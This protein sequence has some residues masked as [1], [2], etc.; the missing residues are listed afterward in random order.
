[1]G[2]NQSIA[3]Y[4]QNEYAKKAYAQES[5][6]A[7][8]WPGMELIRDVLERNGYT[9]E[10]CS[11]HTVHNYRIVLASM[12]APIDWF[13]FISERV[14]WKKGDYTVIVGGAGNLNIRTVLPFADVFVFGRGEN[15]ITPLVSHILQGDRFIHSAVA[16]S[17][18]FS[19][20]QKYY[21]ETVDMPYPYP[22]RLANGKMW[23][24]LAMGCQKKCTF[25]AYSWQRKNV[26]GLQTDT[27]VGD[28]IWTASDERTFFD[29]DL[30]HPET[31]FDRPVPY[32]IVGLDGLSQRLRFMILKYITNDMV[33]KFIYNAASLNIFKIKFYNIVGYPTETEDDWIEFRQV[34]QEID[35]EWTAVQG[36]TND[37]RYNIT[38]HN[39]PFKAMPATPAAI[40]PMAYTDFRPIIART[41]RDK[42]YQQKNTIFR[43]NLVRLTQTPS[44]ESL[45]TMMLWVLMLRGTEEHIDLVTKLS[46]SKQFQNASGKVR[47][48]TLEKYTDI[49]SLFREY[50]WDTLPTKYLETYVPQE[51]MA[52]LTKKVF[53]QQAAAAQQ[54]QQL[55]T[56]P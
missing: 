31:W 20:E 44:T 45:A 42:T 1:M 4:V 40:W 36:K 49:Q 55:I 7:R 16:Y 13:S 22:V 28:Q 14:R 12:T 34:V 18:T 9:V 53:A 51:G 56:I 24:E 26:G 17:D 46:I 6:N 29:F 54:Q 38:I 3:I 32:I 5:Y 21:I 47:R 2:T 25:C 10:Y 33:K 48:A 39:T 8:S 30:D 15:I 37:P 23:K 19:P 52:K 27:G 35:R 11:E 50:T 43:G 41:M